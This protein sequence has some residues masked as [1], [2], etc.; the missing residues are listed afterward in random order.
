MRKISFAV[1][2]I[3][4]LAWAAPKTAEEWYEEGANQYTLGNFDKAIDSFKQGFQLEPDESKKAN[5]L[6]NVAQAYRQV[7]DCKNA[8]FF[9]KRFLAL[10][11]NDT[12]KPIPPKKRKEVEDFI[13]EL[14]VCVRQQAQVSERPPVN[15]VPPD[16]EKPS[17]TS[18]GSNDTRRDPPRKEVATTAPGNT[19]PNDS[20]EE[21]DTTSVTATG[22]S[23]AK[24]ISL[25]FDGGLT[26]MSAGDIHVPA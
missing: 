21:E 18:Q 2:L 11:A 7:H 17:K 8:L 23:Q 19:Q 9:Y 20:A 13:A 5:Y 4:A 24:L 12:T 26:V 6:Y 10:K 1:L 14:D 15:N 3:P 25:R 16:G 22:T